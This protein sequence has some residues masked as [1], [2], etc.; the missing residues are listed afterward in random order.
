M[1]GTGT[2]PGFSQEVLLAV[3]NTLSYA[4]RL[5]SAI[6]GSSIL[7]KYVKESHQNDPLRTV[8][9][10]VLLIFLV[11]YALSQRYKPGQ[12]EIKLTEKEIQE[13]IDEWQPEPLVPDLTDAQRMELDKLVTISG[14][15]GPRVRIEG[16]NTKTLMNLASFNFLGYMNH[17]KL[18]EKATA[19]LRKYGVGTCGP[20]GFYGT[21]DVHMDLEQEL[22]KF[23]NAEAAIIYSQGFSAIAS[24][25]PA[26]SKRGD[27]LVV[28][29]GISFA[30]QKGVEIS[31]SHVKFFKHNDME[32][33]A[34]VLEEIKRDEL[35]KRK[36]L[37]RKF[38]VVEGLYANYGDIAPLPRL[39][40]LKTKYKYRLII[41]ESMSFG[42]LGKRGAGI[43]DHFDVPA[44]DVDIIAASL[45][46][47]LSAA[48]GFCCGSAEIVEHQ[49]LSGQ[50]YTY[51]A[52]LPAMLSVTALESL[53]LLKENPYVLSHMRENARV[54]RATLAGVQGMVIGGAEDAPFV[55]LRV[56]DHLANRIDE[57][58]LLQDIVDEAAKVGYLLTRAKF[59]A[60]QEH[61][62]PP[63]SIR[64]SVSAAHSRVDTE[65]AAKRL[66]DVI[67]TV[68]K[69]K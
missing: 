44:K 67:K 28:D 23:M 11:W 13:L 21:L 66:R 32:D 47:A 38:I 57:E 62:L 43:T 55:H 22:A 54:I 61:N 15:S 9:E 59:V 6:P 40:E 30:I 46:N 7:Y 34:R 56:R 33:L 42:V 39:I 20:P 24:I 8:L 69:K 17:E 10:L 36:P 41:E 14:P 50:A 68:L 45:A 12:K 16:P 29:D 1:A 64:I 51:S 52:S 65:T 2:T 31:R 19:A 37:A 35:K 49:R 25:I 5:Y 63:P 27:T 26:F 18:K 53:H 58:K 4:H 48:G 3:N 60:S